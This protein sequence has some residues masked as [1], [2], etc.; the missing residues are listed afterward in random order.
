M[1]ATP[2]PDRAAAPK[3]Q[4]K[5]FELAAYSGHLFFRDEKKND[6]CPDCDGTLRI[7]DRTFEIAGWL[8]KSESGRDYIYLRIGSERF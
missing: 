8:R 2:T 6:K 5:P 1:S 4:R 7:A 3:P